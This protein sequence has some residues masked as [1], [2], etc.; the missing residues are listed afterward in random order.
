MKREG[1]EGPSPIPRN[2]RTKNEKRKMV[3][4][5]LVKT[6]DRIV[7]LLGSGGY[8]EEMAIVVEA[9]NA[10]GDELAGTPKRGE[11]ELRRRWYADAYNLERLLK[12]MSDLK[13]D[14]RIRI[15]EEEEALNA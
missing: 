9:L 5:D 2:L 13:D 1:T 3:R 12:E 6:N 14:I 4:I 15:D 7:E 11:E 10:K 8:E